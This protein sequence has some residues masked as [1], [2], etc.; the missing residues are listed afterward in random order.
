MTDVNLYQLYDEQIASLSAVEQL[1]LVELI[2]GQLANRGVEEKP[3]RSLL[4]LA[5]AGAHNPVGM[6]A[7]EYVNKLREEWDHRP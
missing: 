3:R 2:V 4:D 5:G 7:Q 1:R 6:D